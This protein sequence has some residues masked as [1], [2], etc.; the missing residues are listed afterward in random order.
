MRKVF[1]LLVI[2]FLVL[3]VLGM[4]CYSGLQPREPETKGTYHYRWTCKSVGDDGTKFCRYV[5]VEGL[6]DTATARGDST[7]N[8]SVSVD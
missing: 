8:N 6:P 2:I 1:I 4:S 3:C 7:C 5:R